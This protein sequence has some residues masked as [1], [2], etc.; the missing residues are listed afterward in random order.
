MSA[1][2]K[3]SSGIDHASL[4]DRV[5][6]HQRYFYD[7]TRKY[8]LLGR[9]TMIAGLNVPQGGSVL[10]IGC[11]TGR[12]L[13]K[14]AKTYPTAKLYGIDISAEM[15]DTAQAAAKRAGIAER[16]E[17]ERADATHFNPVKLFNVDSFDRIFISYAVSMIPQWQ[18]AIAESIQHLKPGGEM[19]I[20]DFGDQQRLPSLFKNALFTWLNW[21]HV[22]PRENLFAVSEQLA[23]EQG[24]HLQKKV[25]HRGFAWIA[26]IRKTP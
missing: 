13:V 12:N 17:L 16:I 26:I 20:V 7:A 19:H 4:M 21:F 5:Y 3:Q 10:E 2:Q 1:H 9:D 22:T 8:Y 6:R 11:G 18:S 24:A 14:T 15:L 25:L 23:K